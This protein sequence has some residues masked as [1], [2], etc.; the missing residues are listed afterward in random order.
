MSLRGC[1]EGRLDCRGNVDGDETIGGEQV[2]LATLVDNAEG[3]VP[4]GA[5]VRTTT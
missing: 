3:A 2:V 1:S 4:L 5:L